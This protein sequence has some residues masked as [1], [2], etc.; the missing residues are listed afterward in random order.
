MKIILASQSERRQD[1]LTNLGVKFQ[2]KPA[3]ICEN[4]EG[5]SP[6]ETASQLALK[7]A[8]AVADKEEDGIVIGADTVVLLGDTVLGKPNDISDAK[9]MLTSLS[10][11]EHLVIT[12]F[13]CI[14]VKRGIEI[15]DKEV[16]TVFFRKLSETII[17]RYV[18]TREPMDKAGAYG[19]QGKGSLLV[20]KINGCYFN[21]VGLPISSLAQALQK[22]DL[23]IM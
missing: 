13:A 7:K 20:E 16:T 3:H 11:N 4:I 18:A 17:D 22:L 19:I 1:I 5:V 2:V 12:G 6:M 23:D 15:V 9:K 14:D 8:R 10:G 21:V